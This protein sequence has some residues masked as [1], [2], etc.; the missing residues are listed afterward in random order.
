MHF[1]LQ[2]LQHFWGFC[3]VFGEF[4]SGGQ[5]RSA[6]ESPR[7]HWFC[8]GFS[9]GTADWDVGTN[10]KTRTGRFYE[11]SITTPRALG[12]IASQGIARVS[13]WKGRARARWRAYHSRVKSEALRS[14]HV[15]QWEPVQ[16][17]RC[18]YSPALQ[19]GIICFWNLLY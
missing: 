13:I 11:V 19:H 15:R 1:S 18:F 3:L 16:E 2:A 12:T 4:F 7:L 14:V 17:G 10:S 9:R 5:N 6:C 8:L